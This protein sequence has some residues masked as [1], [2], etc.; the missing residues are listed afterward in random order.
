MIFVYRRKASEGA[1]ELAEALG[2]RRYR[3]KTI[4]IDTLLESRKRQGRRDTVIC[5]GE[6]LPNI[7]G[8]R[9]LNG[10]PLANKFDDAIKLKAAGVATVSVSRTQQATTQPLPL[11]DPA[12]TIWKESLDLADDFTN[13][14]EFMRGPVL[15]AGVRD[16][17]T[18]FTRL[19]D[20]LQTPP[21]LPL[22]ASTWLPRLNNHVGG[23]DLLATPAI[24]QYWSKKEDLVREFRIHSFQGRSIRA[25]V[26]DHRDG[27]TAPHAWIRSWD[28]GW[29]IKY[30]GVTS[31]QKHR[32]IAHQ[33]VAAL[34]LQFG[35]VDIGERADGS[36][37]VLEVN[38][39]PGVE[40]GTIECYSNAIKEWLAGGLEVRNEA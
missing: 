24:P 36:L 9:I 33:A 13:V 2:A 16:L 20:A 28:G 12:E 10:T 23:N 26:K 38:R 32:D 11:I 1:T 37:I 8:V 17:L 14:E 4:P 15:S 30:D 35:A 40:G 31:K 21:P 18:K 27:F 25:G 29:R 34:G 39:A 19:R 7:E 6:E 22:A 5:W 3:G